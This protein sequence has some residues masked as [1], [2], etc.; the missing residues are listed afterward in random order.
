MVNNNS[1]KNLEKVTNEI[2]I[3]MGG[4]EIPSFNDVF[5]PTKPE[6]GFRKLEY[7]KQFFDLVEVNATFYNTSLSP[8]Q[9]RRWLND[10]SAN[11]R[12]T[13]TVKLY[14]GF[15][16]TFDG[17]RNDALAV[18]RLLEPLRNANKLSGLVA[19]FSSSF[20]KTN[21]RQAYLPKLRAMFPDDHLFLDIRHKSWDD[22][23]FYHFCSE[24]DLHLINVDLPQLK[25]HMP[26]NI[27]AH[28]GDS[29]F[30]NDGTQ[31]RDL[32]QLQERRQISLQLQ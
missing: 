31:H 28:K 17:T 1:K 27:L 12:F 21:E 4:W 20:G 7:Y 8:A 26:F 15:T 30:P 24:N 3:G 11:P 22:Q 6:R 18:H 14:R 5:Y 29:I 32:E 13:F 16:H 19:Q 23:G 2:F 10:V 25:N 9:A